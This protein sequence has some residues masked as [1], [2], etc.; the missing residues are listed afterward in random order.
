[1]KKSALS[2]LILPL[3]VSCAHKQ[4][5]PVTFPEPVEK[6]VEKPV[7]EKP[8]PTDYEPNIDFEGL[9]QYLKMDRPSEKLGYSE[10]SFPTCEVGF[11]HSSNRNCRRDYFVSIHVQI[12]CRDTNEENYTEALGANDMRPMAGSTAKWTLENR[13]GTVTI[14]NDGYAQI[15]KTFHNSPKTKRLKIAIGNE[16]LYMRAGEIN[17]VVTPANW[18]H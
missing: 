10:K 14:D 18:C 2:F 13:S 12:L 6:P 9:E 17:K 1:M 3:L 7:E 5:Q 11:G 15:K 16:N 8:L 4:Q